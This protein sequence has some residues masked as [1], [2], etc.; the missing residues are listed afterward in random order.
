M[1][2]KE[3]TEKEFICRRC[4]KFLDTED[5]VDG[6]CPYCETDED[7]YLNELNDEN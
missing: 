3:E 2:Y 1:A 4:S 5:L 6:K 7:I